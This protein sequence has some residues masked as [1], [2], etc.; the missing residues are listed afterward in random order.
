MPPLAVQGLTTAGTE[1]LGRVHV[2]LQADSQLGGELLRLPSHACSLGRNSVQPARRSLHRLG[3]KGGTTILAQGLQVGKVL[4]FI[5]RLGQVLL[6][7]R[8]DWGASD[9]VGG[10][11]QH[12]EISAGPPKS[13]VRRVAFPTESAVHLRAE[14]LGSQ[15]RVQEGRGSMPSGPAEPEPP[16]TEPSRS[17]RLLVSREVDVREALEARPD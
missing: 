11:H 8:E 3:Q 6:G 2:S 17:L 1:G 16:K 12:V 9:H 10:S 4:R 5:Q 7:W 13:G 14:L 15:A